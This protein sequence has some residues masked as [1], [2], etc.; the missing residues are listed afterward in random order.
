[1]FGLSGLGPRED[2]VCTQCS[3]TRYTGGVTENMHAQL[4]HGPLVPASSIPVK[5]KCKNCGAEEGS[6]KANTLPC[7]FHSGKKEDFT[8]MMHVRG[9]HVKF[10][11]SCCNMAKDYIQAPKQVVDL[12]EDGC[13]TKN[14]HE[15][16]TP[17]K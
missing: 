14:S 8:R 4:G 1:M 16:E 3:W 17:E 13:Q 5:N 10:T 12:H 9:A 15:F 11:W 7:R 6:A 2:M